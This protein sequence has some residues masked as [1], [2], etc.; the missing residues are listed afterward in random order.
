MGLFSSSKIP[1][2]ENHK[3][4]EGYEETPIRTKW[5]MINASAN[6]PIVLNQIQDCSRIC[7]TTYKPLTFEIQRLKDIKPKEEKRM[8]ISEL[9]E[10]RQSFF[11]LLKSPN[12][13]QEALNVALTSF[14]DYIV[15]DKASETLTIFYAV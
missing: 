8:P 2:Y 15:Y 12:T 10:R 4:Y 6:A 1:D 9:K 5:T 7:S 11:E 13:S 3:A 14:I